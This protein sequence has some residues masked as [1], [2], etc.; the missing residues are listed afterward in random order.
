MPMEHRQQ[1]G[2]GQRRRCLILP[3]FVQ[4]QRIFDATS[5]LALHYYSGASPPIGSHAV[6]VVL[7]LSIPVMGQC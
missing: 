6:A 3:S 1:F 5:V 2:H 4:V 7:G